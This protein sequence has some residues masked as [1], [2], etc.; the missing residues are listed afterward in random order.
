M[1]YVTVIGHLFRSYFAIIS[2]LLDTFLL[3][4]EAAA[5]DKAENEK[6]RK[7]KEA[8]KRQVG[9]KTLYS[10]SSPNPHG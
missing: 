7:E 1:V 8:E 3:E 10:D 5:V 6:A 9:V 2:R 4:A